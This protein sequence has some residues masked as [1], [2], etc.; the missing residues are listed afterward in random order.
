MELKLGPE[1]IHSLAELFASPTAMQQSDIPPLTQHLVALHFASTFFQIDVADM[2]GSALCGTRPGNPFADLVCG[3]ALARVS[4]SIGKHFKHEGLIALVLSSTHSSPLC[5]GSAAM[6]QA[7][8]LA[9]IHGLFH[10]V[11][12]PN[13]AVHELGIEY[14]VQHFT[15]KTKQAR[16]MP[17]NAPHVHVSPARQKP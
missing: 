2:L 15:T 11:D 3:Y 12:V 8:M 5:A 1:T 4:A 10:F 16:R 14:V 9:F 17:A 6:E 7:A 13:E